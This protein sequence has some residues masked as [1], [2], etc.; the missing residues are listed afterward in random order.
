M[1]DIF[2]K[3]LPDVELEKS[4]SEAKSAFLSEDATQ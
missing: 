3:D 2:L 4:A 1:K